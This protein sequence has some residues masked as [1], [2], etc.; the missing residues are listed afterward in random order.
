[1]V[2]FAPQS[3]KLR[4]GYFI[5][6]DNIAALKPVD[7]K[8]LITFYIAMQT[9]EKLDPKDRELFNRT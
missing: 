1:M 9:N 8:K 3:G 7:R 4:Q 6:H 5:N 2:F